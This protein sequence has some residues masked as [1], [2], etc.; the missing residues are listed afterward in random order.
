MNSVPSSGHSLGTS[1]GSSSNA[2]ELE[3]LRQVAAGDRT[4][5]KELYLIYHRRLARFLMRM[6]SRHDL[7]EE[8]INDTL[9]TVWLKAGD[10]RGDSLVSTWIVG[11]TYRRALKALRRHGTPRP[12]LVVEDVAVAPDAQLEDENRQW[13]GQA[14]AE[15]PL[16]QRMVMEFSYLMGHSCE[17]I[18][19]IM[20]CPVNTVKTRMF[21]A[22]EKLRRSLPRLAGGNQT[23]GKK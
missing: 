20:Q 3:L 19:T 5:F 2:R 17:E 13:L 14:L 23:G 11:I 21:H 8:V 6:T 7:I 9:W 12:M 10:F 1:S 4:A 16:E 22:R 18:A 15:L